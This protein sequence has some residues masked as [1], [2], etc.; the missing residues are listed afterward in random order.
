MSLIV[1]RR[2]LDFQLYEVARIELLF[3][4][5]RFE[6]LD[7]DSLGS[8]LDLAERLAEEFYLPVAAT[9]DA[10]EPVFLDGKVRLPEATGRALRAFADAGL[11]ALTFDA[12]S[13][14]MQLPYTA[15]M[16]INGIFAAANQSIFNYSML[17]VAAAHLLEAWAD[18]KQK[19]LFLPPLVAGRWFG[20][21]CLSEPQ[22]GSSLADIVTRAEPA[23]DGT[24]RIVG[25][26]MWISGGDH[27]L[28]ENIVHL[29]LARI[30]GAPA[31]VKGISLFIVPKFRV[32]ACGVAPESNNVTLVGLNHKMGQRGT[33]NCLLNFGE[34]GPTLGHLVGEPH[35]GLRYMFHM[36]NEA[37]ITVGHGA[38]AAA[39]AGY[40]YA[41]D[42][43]TERRQ[44]RLPG[45]KAATAAPVAIIHHPDVRRMLLAQKVA[46][47]G[48]Q[49]L[50]LYCAL[51]LDHKALAGTQAEAAD[52][53][54][55][56]Q[57]LTPIAKSWPA[58]HCLEAN[59]LAIQ[60]LGGAGYTRD[61]PVERLYR[62]NRLNHIHEGSYG[63]QGLDLLGRKVRLENGRGLQ[64][65]FE[66]ISE[67]ISSVSGS[68]L[69]LWAGEL[70][71]QLQSWHGATEA[72]RNCP[73]QLL[74]LA[75][76]TA[77]LDAAGHVVLA[78][79][80]LRQAAIAQQRLAQASDSDRVF[81]EGK[82]LSCR[83]CFRHVLP[84]AR[85]AFALVASLDD[86]NLAVQPEHLH[87]GR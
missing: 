41:L 77:Y 51:L 59:K 84:S 72:S 31:G 36:M 28:A 23:G 70:E 49:S 5:G 48:A 13:G 26:K 18:A 74:A 63:I 22:A 14:G 82:F 67:T 35:Q 46:V 68:E 29:V 52:L 62:D 65:L 7:R 60:V 83:Y 44:G 50:I 75:N 33:T 30:A 69:S 4:S 81:Y 73:D 54:L 12:A 85:Q 10:R 53:E 37:R 79:L 38:V 86:T 40:L 8:M 1:N 64:L 56:L 20:T 15:S 9:L 55:L 2:E 57:V 16:A 87:A 76:A 80:W 34:S 42:Y 32:A 11:F 43:A 3:R 61:H 78:W 71:Q 17:T 45:Q 27:D 66:R 47:E 25:A 19:A 24:Y 39:L 6:H 21:M 58:E